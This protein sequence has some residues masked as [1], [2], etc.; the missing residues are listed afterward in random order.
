MEQFKI[1]I[2]VC[3]IIEF[4]ISVINIVAITGAN[5]LTYL[6]TK[7]VLYIKKVRFGGLK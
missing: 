5:S 3:I 7:C 2:R 6:T 4:G 1:T